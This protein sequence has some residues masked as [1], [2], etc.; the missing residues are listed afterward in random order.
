MS[1]AQSEPLAQAGWALVRAGNPRGAMRQFKDALAADPENTNALAGLAQVHLN[2]D[3]LNLAEEAAGDLVRVAPNGATGHR[4]RAEILRRRNRPYEAAKVARE[5]VG[6]D[7][8]EPLGYHILA[9]CSSDQK[10]NKAAIAICDQG[11]AVAP[12]SSVLL[13]Q[14]ADNLL[15]LRGPKAAEANIEEA[16]RISPDSEYVLRV[17]AR[18]ALAQNQLERTRDLLSIILRRN[19]NNR[20]AVSLFLMAEPERHRIL[21]GLY[22]FRYW[23]KENGVLGWATY[24]GVWAVFIVV[25]LLLALVTNVAGL[26]L[27]VGVRFFLKSQY[28]AHARE[29]RAHFAKFALSGGF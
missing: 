24:L 26:L 3:E 6:L 8:R 18:I 17:A 20:A 15:E 27:G 16:L 4:V 28:D 23:R 13:A 5:A 25:A 7:P 11:L 19:A 22:I 21:R 29:V 12:A 10:E 9:M 14:R 1:A 2:L